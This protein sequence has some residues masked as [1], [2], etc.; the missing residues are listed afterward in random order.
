MDSS[1]IALLSSANWAIGTKSGLTISFNLN[2]FL[3]SFFNL[4]D[5]VE[6]DGV[7]SLVLV[8][9]DEGFGRRWVFRSSSALWE[10]GSF[11]LGF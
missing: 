9:S 10:M 1:F 11:Q 2:F 4:V 3:S 8:F 7:F 5:G 6:V